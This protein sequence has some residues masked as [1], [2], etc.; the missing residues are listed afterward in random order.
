MPLDATVGGANA[1]S[2]L[3]VADA[4]AYFEK[5]IS[6]T[7]EIWLSF[8]D[9]AEVLM[10]ATARLELEEYV[11]TRASTTQA[12]KWPRYNVPVPDGLGSYYLPTEIPQRI[13]D[14]TCEYA[15]SLISLTNN[16]GAIPMKSLRIGNSVEAVFDSTRAIIDEKAS[17]GLIPLNAAMLLRGFRLNSSGVPMVRA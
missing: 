7:G 5:Q 8:L 15:L 16:G 9:Q 6:T 3:T 10:T 17:L 4:N 12:L 11:G 1:N 2:Y 14:A 13:K